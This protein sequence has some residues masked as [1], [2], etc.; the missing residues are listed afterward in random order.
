VVALCLVD[1]AY[2]LPDV[3]LAL[4]GRAAPPRVLMRAPF[5]KSRPFLTVTYK[6][7]REVRATAL[8][9]HIHDL[10]LT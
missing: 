6:F 2:H 4:D 3:L 1:V 10:W 5:E 8:C 9:A 7:L